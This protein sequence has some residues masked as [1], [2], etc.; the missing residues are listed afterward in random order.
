MEIQKVSFDWEREIKIKHE[1]YLSIYK[2]FIS[3]SNYISFFFSTHLGASGIPI[4]CLLTWGRLV[5][6]TFVGMRSARRVQLLFSHFCWLAE[7]L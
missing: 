5:F 7:C 3:D 6:L 1:L 2:N 4:F